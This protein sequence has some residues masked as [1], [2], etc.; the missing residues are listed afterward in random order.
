M[1]VWAGVMVPYSMIHLKHRHVR[2]LGYE[3]RR[4]WSYAIRGGNEL[5][6]CIG[7]YTAFV[8]R[9]DTPLIHIRSD[10]TTGI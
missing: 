5:V 1:G 2:A 10:K 4:G 7:D 3:P 8:D 6:R 9:L